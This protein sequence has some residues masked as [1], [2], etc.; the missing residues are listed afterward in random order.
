MCNV[1]VW[2]CA[3]SLLGLTILS[4][5]SRWKQTMKQERSFAQP[6]SAVLPYPVH[7]VSCHFTWGIVD[8]WNLMHIHSV[9]YGA[10]NT[11]YY[12]ET[13]VIQEQHPGR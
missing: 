9:K 11:R 3:A 5:I 2:L 1:A 7:V 13:L 12:W 10:Y 6:A 8:E 4:G